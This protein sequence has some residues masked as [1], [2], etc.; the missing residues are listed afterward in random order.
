MSTCQHCG[1]ALRGDA[2]VCTDCQSGVNKM[3]SGANEPQ[4]RQTDEQEDDVDRRGLLLLFGLG[5]GAAGGWFAFLRDDG[6]KSDDS[7]PGGS[8]SD[9]GSM[10]G[11]NETVDD[12]SEGTDDG[13]E[14]SENL[15]PETPGAN[16]ENAPEV[17][18]G[19]HGPYQITDGEDHFFSVD[20]SEG[21]QLTA[22]IEFSHSEGDLELSLFDANQNRQGRGISSDDN[23]TLSLTAAQSGLHYIN[24][25]GFRGATNE[26]E[27]V[28]EIS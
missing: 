17:S 1:A 15:S 21:E 24:P 10:D 4:P 7:G 11:E 16:F 20:L 27:L 5:L 6:D 14:G 3:R 2:I 8:D 23:E 28:V 9:D 18:A 19:R 22:T 25:Y 12:G 13:S 26:Y